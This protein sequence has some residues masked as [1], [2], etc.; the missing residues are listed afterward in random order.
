MFVVKHIS[1]LNNRARNFAMGSVE[2]DGIDLR[3]TVMSE[4]RNYAY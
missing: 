2:S 3:I 4:L 1:Y